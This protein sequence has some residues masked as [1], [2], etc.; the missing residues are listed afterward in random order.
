MMSSPDLRGICCCCG[1]KH[2]LTAHHILPKS[3][4]GHGHIYNGRSNVANLCTGCHESINRISSR[5]HEMLDVFDPE[6]IVL[7][8]TS[9]YFSTLT[10]RTVLNTGLIPLDVFA[11]I[12]YACQNGHYQHIVRL[13]EEVRAILEHSEVK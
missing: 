2:D 1:V 8:L 3:F 4:A 13:N 6:D 10:K 7:W 12:Q 5:Y 9:L 11:A